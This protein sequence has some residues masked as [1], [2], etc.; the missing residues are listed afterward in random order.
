MAITERVFSGVQPTGNLHL[1][2]YLGAIVNFVKLQETHNC[3][4]CV[5]DMHALTQ[6]VSVWGGPAELARNTREVTAAFIASGIDPVRQPIPVAPAAHY[7][8]GGIASD[9][10]GRA[11]LDG[12]WAV[13]ECASTGLHGA[14]RLASNSLLEALVFGARAADD[15]KAAIAPREGHGTPPAPERFA[16]PAPPHVLREAMTRLVGLE[17]DEEGL[18]EALG[19]IAQV[20]RAGASEPA[21]LNMTASAKLVAAAALARRE[22]RGGHYR[23]DYPSADEVGQRTFLTLAQAEASIGATAAARTDSRAAN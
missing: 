16:A 14:N 10:R 22:S 13:G 7:H 21:L 4:Y 15:V 9:E 1:G 12:L 23:K 20:E 8:M 17:R 19:I 11:S 3:L 6:P 2:N 18:R 5:V